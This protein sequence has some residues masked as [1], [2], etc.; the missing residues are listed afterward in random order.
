MNTRM[1]IDRRESGV[2]TGPMITGA[3]HERVEEFVAD[4]TA[5]GAR[6]VCGGGRVDRAGFFLQPTL[7]YN[8]HD[9]MRA[10]REEVFGPVMLVRD[11][12]SLQD[13]LEQANNTPYGLAGYVLGR[14]MSAL[15][16]ATEGLRFGIVGVN[17]MTPATAEGPFGGMKQSGF[18]RE[19]SQEGLAEYLETKFVSIGI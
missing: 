1:Y 18:G 16:R 8:L 13:A 5:Q 2:T 11:V 4:A 17:D 9:D 15:I 3:G 6:V 10:M 14:D 19:N 7:L 12:E